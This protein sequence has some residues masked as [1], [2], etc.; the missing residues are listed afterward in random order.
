VQITSVVAA[1]ARIGGHPAVTWLLA[2]GIRISRWA[3]AHG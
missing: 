1:E 3:L 2:I